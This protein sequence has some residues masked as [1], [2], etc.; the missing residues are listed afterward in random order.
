MAF[1]K[2]DS[3]SPN[4]ST[5][6]DGFFTRSAEEQHQSK[7][8]RV[9]AKQK[10]SPAGL[11]DMPKRSEAQPILA[12]ASGVGA[13]AATPEGHKEHKRHPYRSSK[14]LFKRVR[15]VLAI[16]ILLGCCL[17]GFKI[18]KEVTKFTSSHSLSAQ[19]VRTW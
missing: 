7:N 9:P 6:V 15:L 19:H 2:Q 16:A 8:H 5:N 3:F 14:R 18:Y 13:I 11:R 17:L 4:R 10:L 1:E 12:S